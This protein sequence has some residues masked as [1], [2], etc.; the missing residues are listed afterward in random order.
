MGETMLSTSAV[1]LADIFNLAVGS[2]IIH[3]ICFGLVAIIYDRDES[4]AV[5]SILYLFFVIIN[6]GI[7]T[8][9]SYGVND[10][11]FK[12]IFIRCVIGI[13]LEI[14]I[15]FGVRNLKNNIMYN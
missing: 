4:P 10:S 6:S 15:L 13:I 9:V 1:I 8:L 2:L 11:D 5:G 3:I 7:I 12:K 14:G